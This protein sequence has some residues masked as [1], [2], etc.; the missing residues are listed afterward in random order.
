MY[1]PFLNP[2]KLLASHS[3]GVLPHANIAPTTKE[4]C[5]CA[6]GVEKQRFLPLKA[7]DSKYRGV[8]Y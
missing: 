7:F 2:T 1:N 4:Q 5:S 3:F 6:G 8:I